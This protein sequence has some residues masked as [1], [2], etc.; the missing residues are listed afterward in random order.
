MA[1]TRVMNRRSLF[2]STLQPAE[3]HN[4]ASRVGPAGNECVLDV[5]TF[6]GLRQFRIYILPLEE[7]RLC[8]LFNQ[9]RN[10]AEE[11]RQRRQRPSRHHLGRI[12]EAVDK[13]LDSHSVHKSRKLEATHHLAQERR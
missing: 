1:A 13:I 2:Y 4:A 12:T 9:G 7:Q 10:V 6:R 8:T 3:E 11:L 5:P